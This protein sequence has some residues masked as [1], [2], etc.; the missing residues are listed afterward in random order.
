MPHY[1]NAD[2]GPPSYL[3]YQDCTVHAL[4]IST[5]TPYQTA[6]ALLAAFGRKPRRGCNFDLFL[7]SH[8]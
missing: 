1:V 7:K 5:S 4:R 6:H 8:N 2:E 3:E